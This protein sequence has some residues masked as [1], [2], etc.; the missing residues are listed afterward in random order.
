MVTSQGPTLDSPTDPGCGRH[1]DLLK[2]GGGEALVAAT[3]VPFL[4]KMPL[5]REVVA[6]G[7][8]GRV[9]MDAGSQSASA[10]ALR[11]IVQT[12]LERTRPRQSI[13]SILEN[14]EQE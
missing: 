13:L 2:T 14:K 4:G 12:V 7:D 9:S 6:N 10:Q 8:S 1:L 11:A 3:D 5:D